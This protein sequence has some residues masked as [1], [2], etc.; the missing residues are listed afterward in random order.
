MACALEPLLPVEH[1][2]YGRLFSLPDW[3][4]GRTPVSCDFDDMMWLC[5]LMFAVFLTR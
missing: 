5:G 2:W 1:K 3:Y 4:L